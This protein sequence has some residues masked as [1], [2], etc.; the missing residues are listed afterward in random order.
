[1]ARRRLIGRGCDLIPLVLVVVA[2]KAEQLPVASVRRIVVV[3]MVFVVDRELAQLLA[4]EF[5]SAMGAEPWKEFERVLS[6]G[7]V[8]LGLIV[9][10]HASLAE[11]GDSCLRDS[12]ISLERK[13]ITGREGADPVSWLVFI[14]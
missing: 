13:P 11:D 1:M 8:T 6:M 7:L 4:V 14:S 9:P 5:P 12:T 2:V 10:C 3:V